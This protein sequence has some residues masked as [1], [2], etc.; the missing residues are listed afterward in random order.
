MNEDLQKINEYRKGITELF[1]II[2]GHKDAYEGKAAEAI[3]PLKHSFGN[4]CYIREI[5]MPANQIIVSKI[6][7]YTHPYFILKGEV[8][9]LTE[10]GPVRLKAPYYGMTPAGT[11]RLLYIHEETVWVTVHVTNKTNVDEAVED[12]TAPDF[13]S[14]PEHENPMLLRIKHI[15]GDAK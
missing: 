8:S 14:L 15:A 10:D 12:V 11:Q 9:V 2:K 5:T 3:N 6:H 13:E 1:A 7:K 4:G